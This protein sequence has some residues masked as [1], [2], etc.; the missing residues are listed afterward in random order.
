MHERLEALQTV[1]ASAVPPQQEV[2]TS[3]ASTEDRQAERPPTANFYKQRSM[4]TSAILASRG[5]K[6]AEEHVNGVPNG[7]SKRY[8]VSCGVKQD[9]QE[10]R[11]HNRWMELSTQRVDNVSRPF[12]NIISDFSRIDSSA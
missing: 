3:T 7:L 11:L 8:V 6:D 12:L 2:L 1:L 5:M 10:V 4:Q 9:G